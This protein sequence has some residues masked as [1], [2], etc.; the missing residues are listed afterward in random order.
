MSGTMKAAQFEPGGPEKLH[1][2]MVAVPELKEHQILIKVFASEINR[3]DTL[4]V[5]I[6]VILTIDAF[7]PYVYTQRLPSGDRV[8]EGV[9]SSGVGSSSGVAATIHTVGLTGRLAS[10][11]HI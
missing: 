1:T 5:A 6:K 4:Q 10:S 9:A 3:A 7:V 11:G 2:G 8:C